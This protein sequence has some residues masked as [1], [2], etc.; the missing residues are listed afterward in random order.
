M[1]E[2]FEGTLQ[3]NSGESSQMKKWLELKEREQG[4]GLVEYALILVLVAVVSIVVMGTMGST[5]SNVFCNV[6]KTLNTSAGCIPAAAAPVD[7]AP[8]VA[9]LP[10][11]IPVNSPG[12]EGDTCIYYDAHWHYIVRYHNGEWAEITDPGGGI[13]QCSW[14]SYPT[15]DSREAG[16]PV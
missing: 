5:I 2:S 4:Q 6:V 8:P 10:L 12:N 16:H 11:G 15:N 14:N 13:A 9:T 3:L 1:L 7:S